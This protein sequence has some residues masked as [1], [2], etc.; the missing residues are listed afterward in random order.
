MFGESAFDERA[1]AVCLA[2]PDGA[3][4]EL[5]LL[6]VQSKYD[7]VIDHIATSSLDLT[8]RNEGDGQRL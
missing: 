1:S 8:T 4:E 2:T 5:K 6:L 7:G 3:V